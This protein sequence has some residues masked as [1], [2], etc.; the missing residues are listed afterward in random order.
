MIRTELQRRLRRLLSGSQTGVPEWTPLVEEGDDPGLYAPNDAPWVV[1]ADIATTIGGI[2]SLLVQALHPGS[3][4]GVMQHSRYE[5]DVLGRL[6]GTIR[7][8]T[9]STFGSR[10][11]IS[12]EA[13]RVRGMHDRVRGKYVSNQ[14]ESRSYRASDQDLLQW[15][16]LAFTDSFLVAHSQYGKAAIPG[17]PD[18]YVAQ[19]ANAVTALGLAEPPTSAS[20]LRRMMAR[21][22]AELVVNEKTR[23]VISFIKSAPLP[24]AARPTYRV[25]FWAAVDLLPPE[26]ARR[27]GIRIPPRW[28]VRPL[29]TAVLRV[30]R[31]IIGSRSPLEDAAL[32]R[33]ERLGHTGHRVAQ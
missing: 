28:L 29:A 4:A 25:L 31:M 19:W 10:T 21:Y 1:H 33:I 8:L 30:M 15:V 14:Q 18:A 26:Y 5:H 2:R 32:R 20:E 3:L 11:A 23:N 12:N 17:G 24:L 9:I 16:H 13:M 27:I 6:H 22:D 7:W